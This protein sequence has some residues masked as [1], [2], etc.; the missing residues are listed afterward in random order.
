MNSLPYRVKPWMSFTF[1]KVTSE[2][3][4]HLHRLAFRM[5]DGNLGNFRQQ[6][7]LW[8][9]TLFRLCLL[10][11]DLY[12]EELLRRIPATAAA[13]GYEWP[14]H[15]LV[16]SDD[17][18][19]WNGDDVV[20]ALAT[21]QRRLVEERGEPDLFGDRFVAD[22]KSACSIY[23][24][25]Y[26]RGK[27]ATGD[28]GAGGRSSGRPQAPSAGWDNGAA[29]SSDRIDALE[30]RVAELTDLIKHSSEETERQKAAV[31]RI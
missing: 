7:T 20:S 31:R 17:A 28:A 30:R 6:V 22:I 29:A 16:E 13:A 18:I 19:V 9:D 1:A 14:L 26:R 11:N 15:H 12:E 8:G 2:T 4:Y 10:H 27:N 23:A 24:T 5:R 21:V 3:Y 25:K